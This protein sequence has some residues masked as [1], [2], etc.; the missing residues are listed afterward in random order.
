MDAFFAAVEQLDH[1]EYR[2]RPVIVGGL[3]PRGVVSTASY[4]A[5]PYGVRSALPMAVARRLCPDGIYVSPRFVR[6]REISDHVRTILRR[7]SPTIETLSLDEAFFDLSERGPSF[8]A[9][10]QA[11]RTIKRDVQAETKLT[12]SVGLAPNRFLAKLGSEMNKPDGFMVIDPDQ[13]HEILDPLPVG[14]IWGVGKV[15]ARRLASLGVLRV[16]DLRFA[17]TDLLVRELGSTGRRL[18]QLAEGIDDTPLSGE[19]DSKSISRETTY[20]FDVTDLN[21]MEAEARRL[22]GHVARSLQ[23]ENLTCRVVRIK[24]RYPDF[25]TI[26]R[27][28]QLS[29]GT[30]SHQVIESLVLELLRKRVPLDEGGIRLLGVGLGGI[31]ESLARQLPLFPDWL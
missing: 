29:V 6:Y 25:K 31:V 30:D 5:R 10:H 20:S 12:C 24:V 22:A 21:E 4:E 9:V 17:P 28:S 14:Q 18:Q 3:G 16:K 2:G 7:F 11:A 13:V 8:E 23:A 27:Q 15:T 1:P 26:T 19:V